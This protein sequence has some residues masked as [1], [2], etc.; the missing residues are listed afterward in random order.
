M[1]AASQCEL[2]SGRI[3]NESVLAERIELVL[4]ILPASRWP[5]ETIERRAR[6]TAVVDVVLCGLGVCPQAWR[7]TF[8]RECGFRSGLARGVSF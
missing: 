3:D 5:P 1:L 8:D 2:V 4:K 7:E 6:C